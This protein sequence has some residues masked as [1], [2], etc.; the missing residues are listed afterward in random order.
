MF[1]FDYTRACICLCMRMCMRVCFQRCI[2]RAYICGGMLCVR[3]RAGV[4][5]IDRS[6]ISSMFPAKREKDRSRYDV[7]KIA[8]IDYR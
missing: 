8:T 7:D 6:G 1:D 2:V 3:V 5:G 4:C